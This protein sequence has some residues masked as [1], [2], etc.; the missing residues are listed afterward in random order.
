MFS[1]KKGQ[2]MWTTRKFKEIDPPPPTLST[3]TPPPPPT[4]AR[5]TKKTQTLSNQCF[6]KKNLWHKTS[7]CV[8]CVFFM[9]NTG[10]TNLLCAFPGGQLKPICITP[11]RI[12]VF[13]FMCATPQRATTPTQHQHQ[14]QHQ[15]QHQH[16][17][18]TPTPFVFESLCP[19]VC[20]HK[21]KH[22]HFISYACPKTSLPNKLD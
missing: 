22:G 3:H 18:P 14:H 5:T 7:M 19:L 16:L 20:S 21:E 9:K 10:S 1:E 15:R 12:G 11:D 8:F 13:L 2:K 4:L 6:H 17:P